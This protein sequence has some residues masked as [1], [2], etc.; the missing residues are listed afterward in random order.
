MKSKFIKTYA[1]ISLIIFIFLWLAGILLIHLYFDNFF[2]KLILGGLLFFF[3][4]IIH[5]WLS[6]KIT[7]LT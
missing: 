1:W 4:L 6:S 5:G 3:L 2:T 7:K